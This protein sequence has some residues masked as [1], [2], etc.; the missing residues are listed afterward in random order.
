MTHSTEK[1]RGSVRLDVLTSREQQVTALVCRGYPNKLI[2]QELNLAEGT[3][4][5][6]LHKVFQKLN[7]SNRAALM[8][9]LSNR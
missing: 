1:E 3:V 6:H 7:V 2:A 5:I 8:V 9:K 4:K